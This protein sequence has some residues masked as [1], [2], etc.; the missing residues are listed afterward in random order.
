LEQSFFLLK[1]AQQFLTPNR[2]KAELIEWGPRLAV[3]PA[4]ARSNTW[5]GQRLGPRP[6]MMF[7]ALFMTLS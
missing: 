1:G 3:F 4:W 7:M 2:G 6:M 5:V